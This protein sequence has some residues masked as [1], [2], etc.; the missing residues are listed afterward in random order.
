MI[1]AL[2][3][4]VAV[5]SAGSFSKVARS[6]GVAVSSV[7]RRVDWLEAELGAK[8]FSRS[9]RRLVL[10]DAGEQF[11]PRARGIIA[12]MAEAKESLAALKS[13]PRG[14]LTVTAPAM[15]GRQHVV[16]AVLGFL[17]R[18]PLLEVDLHI[19]DEVIDLA[20]RRVDVAIRI[21][22]LTDSDLV[23]TRLAPIRRLVC[24]SPEYLDRAGRPAHPMGL[25][26]HNC[27]T[28]ASTLNPV[29]WWCFAGVNRNRALP[30]RGNLRSE[31]TGTLLAAALAGVGI[32]HLASWLVSDMLRAGRLV[33]LFP[34]A[35]PPEEALSAIHAVRMSGR[36]HTAKA[37]LL[38][39]HVRK[40]FGAPPYWDRLPNHSFNS[41]IEH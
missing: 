11:L 12:D 24:A 35:Q 18:Y 38:V 20:A 30:V 4:F 15:F 3:T 7:S 19:G 5:A 6:Q 14:L 17:K 28:V 13:E 10:T 2:P 31:D 40:A 39:D 34:D 9:S 8:L 26:E 36:S 16:P 23:A 33:S 41:D 32:V 21:G 22:R 1:D 25:L 27:L 37:K 29:G